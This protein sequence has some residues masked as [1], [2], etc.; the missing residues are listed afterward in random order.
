M[1]TTS[2]KDFQKLLDGKPIKEWIDKLVLSKESYSKSP[3]GMFNGRYE[4]KFLA[5]LS[6][7]RER[8]PNNCEEFCDYIFLTSQVSCGDLKKITA[9]SV[10]DKT[11]DRKSSMIGGFPWTDDK[12]PWPETNPGDSKTA[13]L[14]VAQLNLQEI[15]RII[16]IKFP[17]VLIQLWGEDYFRTINIDEIDT[18]EWNYP[19]YA[20]NGYGSYETCELSGDIIILDQKIISCDTNCADNILSNNIITDYKYDDNGDIIDEYQEIDGDIELFETLHN[21]V[22]EIENEIKGKIIFPNPKNYNDTYSSYVRDGWRILAG[23]HH[24][25]IYYRHNNGDFE[26]ISTYS[27]S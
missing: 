4:L 13:L 2:D 20:G 27:P 8:F 5:A 3:L 25:S 17:S 10:R 12:N 14:P 6:V 18:P 7:I 22:Y 1:T 11:L 21:H 9:K 16:G 26:F 24:W 15:S 23:S 19:E